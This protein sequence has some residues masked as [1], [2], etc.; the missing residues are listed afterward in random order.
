MKFNTCSNAAVADADADRQTSMA[1]VN[2]RINVMCT[3]FLILCIH[4]NITANI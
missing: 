1:D 2:R 3:L 4:A